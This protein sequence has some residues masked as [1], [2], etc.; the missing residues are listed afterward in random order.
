MYLSHPNLVELYCA[1]SD[2]ENVYL[3]QQLGINGQLY[4]L[5]KKRNKFSQ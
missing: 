3:I 5:M 2:K 4:E 1:F